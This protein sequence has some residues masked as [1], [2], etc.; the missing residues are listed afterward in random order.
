MILFLTEK[1][2]NKNSNF[3]NGLV[4]LNYVVINL[5]I[6]VRVRSPMNSD[7]PKR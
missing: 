7:A 5:Y 4:G 6:V 1:K 2:R 3:S